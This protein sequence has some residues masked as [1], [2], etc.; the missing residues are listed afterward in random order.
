MKFSCLAQAVE[1]ATFAHQWL[2][3]YLFEIALE[4]FNLF[5]ISYKEC[6]QLYEIFNFYQDKVKARKYIQ[7]LIFNFYDKY[8]IL[9]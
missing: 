8:I 1:V 4:Q 7:V 9:Q 6:Q 3:D 5:E 2:I